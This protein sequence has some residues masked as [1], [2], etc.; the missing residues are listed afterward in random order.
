[1]E[2]KRHPLSVEDQLYAKEQIEKYDPTIRKVIR[3]YLNEELDADFEDI[4]QDVYETICCQLDDFRRYDAPEALVVTITRRAVGKYFRRQQKYK[5]KEAPLEENLDY[6][7]AEEDRG[8]EDIFPRKLSPDDRQILI[9]TYQNM[10][11]SMEVA[12]DLGEKPATIRRRLNRAR[13][14]LKKLLE[15][16]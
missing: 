13:E 10:D 15:N 7:A 11:T 14:R 4:V 12:A 3:I 2:R 5:D 1:M 6:P 16:F 9:R 8:L